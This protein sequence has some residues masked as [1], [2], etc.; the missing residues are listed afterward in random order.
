MMTQA[1]HHQ[2]GA[3]NSM[4][5]QNT[6]VSV[7]GPLAGSVASL[8]FAMRAIISMQ[9]WLHDPLCLEMPWRID[10][11]QQMAQLLTS[12]Q[13]LAFG[14]VKHDGVVQPHPPV[15]R[16]VDIVTE[17]LLSLGH[18]VMDW[19]PDPPH[20]N[21]FDITFLSWQYDGGRNVHEAFALSGEPPSP[22]IEGVYGKKP[23]EEKTATHIHETNVAKREAQKS[24]MEYWN[25]SAETTGTG[26]PVDCIICP[27]APSA[28]AAPTHMRHYAN[29]MWVNCLDCKCYS[30]SA[31]VWR[32]D[33]R[34]RH[35]RGDTSDY[36]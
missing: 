19:Q 21:L 34:R 3:A 27:V 5:G 16:G 15:S 12:G 18:K 9:P 23:K 4:D 26:R 28:A 14:V 2:P 17:A 32:A 7:I 25:S 1:N 6:V 36:R 24:Y 31:S 33:D 10:H 11:E 35:I 30:T 22:Q 29:T 13:P 20:M 8:Q